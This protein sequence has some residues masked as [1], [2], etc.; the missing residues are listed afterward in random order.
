MTGKNLLQRV[1]GLCA[2]EGEC[3]IWHGLTARGPL[4]LIKHGNSNLSARRK[5]YEFVKGVML[6]P[7]QVVRTTCGDKLCMK[8]SHLVAMTRDEAKKI[9]GANGA[10]N[11]ARMQAIRYKTT[12]ARAKLTI[13]IARDIRASDESD[14]A[15]AKKYGVA[16]K[17]INLIRQGMAWAEVFSPFA[18]LIA[19]NDSG[20]KRA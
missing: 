16:H 2:E 3:L 14:R 4:P 7:N 19:A 9:D 6:E 13:E 18:G 20:R 5:L 11:S 8:P 12:R 10:Y 15:L 17:Q 1:E